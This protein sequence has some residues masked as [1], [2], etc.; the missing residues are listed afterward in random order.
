MRSRK[1]GR[2]YSGHKDARDAERSLPRQRL[3]AKLIGKIAE[4][5]PATAGQVVAKRR[6]ARGLEHLGDEK[7]LE[8]GGDFGNDGV[9]FGGS[10]CLLIITGERAACSFAI[11]KRRSRC[12][13]S[14]I[15]ATRRAT[16]LRNAGTYRL[17]R[18]RLMGPRLRG[19]DDKIVEWRPVT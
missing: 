11:R 1:L 9:G 10:R 5:R 7:G 8:L 19:G 15:P 17:Q 12:F 4:G 6:G 3:G 14:V 13:V 16:R 2:G 18:S